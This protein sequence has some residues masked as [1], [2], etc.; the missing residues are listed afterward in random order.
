MIRG[1]QANSAYLYERISEGEYR[2]VKPDGLHV[3]KRGNSDHAG[4]LL[5]ALIANDDRQQATAHDV[6]AQTPSAA[7]PERVHRLAGRRAAAVN[8]RR[9]TLSD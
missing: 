1:R 3:M 8:H 6:A 5:R 2:P 9:T 7:L 4:Q